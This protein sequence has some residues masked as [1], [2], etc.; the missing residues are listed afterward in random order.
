MTCCIGG[1]NGGSDDGGSDDGGS[2]RWCITII[3]MV[4]MIVMDK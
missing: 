1:D 2:G 4:A 3:I